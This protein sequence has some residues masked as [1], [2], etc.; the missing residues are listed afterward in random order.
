MDNYFDGIDESLK[1]YFHILSEDIPDFLSDY[2]NTPR[3]RKQAGIAVSCGIFYSKMF[4]IKWYSSLDHSVAVAL[5]IWHF[6]KDKKQTLAGLFHDIAT[7]C[8]KHAIDYMYGDYETQESTEELTEKLIT[9]S[10][11][12]MSLLQRDQI[13]V[14]EISNY[15]IYPIADNDTPKLSSDRLEYTLANGYGIIFDLWDEDELKKIYNDIEIQ[16]NEDGIQELGFKSPDIAE[17]FAINLKKLSVEYIKD[18][19]RFSLQFIADVMRKLYEDGLISIEDLY[20]LSE[21]DIINIIEN[22]EVGSI[23]SSFRKWRNAN[24]IKYSEIPVEGVYCVK[25]PKTKIRYINPLV[26]Y[27]GGY[28]RILDISDK[29]KKEM[30]DVLHPNLYKHYMYMD[31]NL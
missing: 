31:F 18:K 24:D 17:K 23:S 22:C 19:T 3:M 8:F 30:E 15:H 9:N 13:E 20:Q 4:N 11:E 5:I 26:R 2:I 12:I 25:V 14:K 21:K 28:K 7:P 6:T 1:K 16:V 10:K 27:N 29:A